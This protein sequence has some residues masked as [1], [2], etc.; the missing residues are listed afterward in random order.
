MPEVIK[1]AAIQYPTGIGLHLIMLSKNRRKYIPLY[2]AYKYLEGSDYILE[3]SKRKCCCRR[4]WRT[5][6]KDKKQAVLFGAGAVAEEYLDKYGWKQDIAFLVDN[7]RE[8]QNTSFKGYLV[9]NPEEI[10]KYGGRIKILITNKDHEADIEAQLQNMGIE[11]YYFYCSMQS[12][13]IRN[14]IYRRI[15]QLYT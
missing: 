12:K 2:L 1:K 3:E 15:I 10:L 6:I 7:D 5:Y 4:G 9:K 14:I 11:R 8:K 13:R